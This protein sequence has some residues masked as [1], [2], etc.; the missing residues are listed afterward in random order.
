MAQ[1]SSVRK[2]QA[3]QPLMWSHQSLIDLQVGR[4]T[5][6]ALHIDP[7]LLCVEAERLQCAS[8]TSQLNG[9]D[10]LVAAVV[11]G[12]RVAFRVLIG[13]GRAKGIENSTGCEVLRGDEHDGFP[14]PLNFLFL[15]QVDQ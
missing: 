1:M 15:S 5:T 6:Q 9:V 13:H 14:L 3:H 11:S 12:T 4:T 10:V 2:I 7:P 8:L